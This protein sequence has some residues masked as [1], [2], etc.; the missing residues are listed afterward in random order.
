MKK[1]AFLFSMFFIASNLFAQDSTSYKKAL[2]EM[3]AVSGAKATYNSVINQMVANFKED[4]PEIPVEVWD[5]F[6]VA[7]TEKATSDIV[8]LILPIYQK[9]LTEEDLKNLTI[10]YKSPT[11]S[12]M[13]RETPFIMQESMQAGRVWGTKIAQEFIQKLKDEGYNMN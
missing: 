13:A 6:G 10:F 5:K 4:K 12:K 7:F 8:D 3:M 1:I 9:H 11:G 2:T